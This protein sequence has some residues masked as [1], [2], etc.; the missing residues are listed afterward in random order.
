MSSIQMIQMIALKRNLSFLLLGQKGGKNR[1]E[2]IDLLWDRPYNINQISEKLKLNYR[3]VKHHI[4]IL[5]KYQLIS[6][7]KTGGYGDVFFLSP[8]LEGNK[9]IY[10]SVIRKMDIV[11]KLTDLTDSPQ[12]FKTVLQQTYEGVIIVDHDWDVVF[13]NNSASR[14]FGF[15]GEE[16]LHGPLDIFSKEPLFKDI[17]KKLAKEGRITDLETFGKTL[18]GERIDINLTIDPICLEDKQV[19][20]YSILTMDISERKKIEAKLSIKRNILEVIMENAGTGIAYLDADF[21]ILKANSTF[22][23]ESGHNKEDLI[24]KNHFEIFKNKEN[25]SLFE[26]VKRSGER[27]EVFDRPYEFQDQPKRGVSYWNWSLVPVKD[28]SD[29]VAS[30]VLTLKET[31]PVKRKDIEK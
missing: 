2:I 15:R 1:M 19:I 21:N 26:D 16:D 25:L 20:G 18:S 23:R 14:I 3:T 10:N 27:I 28:D 13:W 11:K 12:F 22:A 30:L 17:K 7:S 4:N 8:D 6:S 24:G 9:D 5:L 29:I 31:N